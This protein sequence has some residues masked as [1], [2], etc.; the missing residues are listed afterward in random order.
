MSRFWQMSPKDHRSALKVLE[1]RRPGL[2]AER[3]GWGEPAYVFVTQRETR[4]LIAEIGQWLDDTGI[5][6]RFETAG[7]F[8]FIELKTEADAVA[9]KLR[10]V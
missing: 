6:F 8:T 4:D 5:A 10:W 3:A 2:L 1:H 9:F 7:S